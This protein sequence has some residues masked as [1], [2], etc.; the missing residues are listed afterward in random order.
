MCGIITDCRKSW[1]VIHLHVCIS[2]P[3]VHCLKY[4][5]STFHV[6]GSMLVWGNGARN[7][8]KTSV[9]PY[10]STCCREIDNEQIGGR[11]CNGKNKGNNEEEQA[12]KARGEAYE[13]LVL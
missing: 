12:G 6:S 10:T 5:L 7:T 13:I 9:S 1:G 2:L 4:L 3:S 8:G 11:K